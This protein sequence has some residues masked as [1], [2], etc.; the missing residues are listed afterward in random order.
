MRAETAPEPVFRHRHHARTHRI[1]IDIAAN[2]QQISIRI[3]HDCLKPALKNVAHQTVAAVVHL[4][5]M[6]VDVT[7]Q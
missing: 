5:V 7:H 6:A 3:D 2:F 4:A 1:E